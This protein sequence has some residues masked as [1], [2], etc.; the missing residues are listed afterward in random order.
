M[1]TIADPHAPTTDCDGCLSLLGDWEDAWGDPPPG[2]T[3]HGDGYTA[4][5]QGETSL[6][7]GGRRTA[8]RWVRAGIAGMRVPAPYRLNR[9]R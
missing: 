2:R 8:A 3:T 9:P 7:D 6:A 5:R 4:W 1:A